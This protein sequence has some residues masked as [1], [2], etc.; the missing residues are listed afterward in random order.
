M[1]LS[2]LH[3]ASATDIMEGIDPS[4]HEKLAYLQMMVA[5]Q[6]K[7]P[8]PLITRVRGMIDPQYAQQAGRKATF[9]SW[10]K[11]A[12]R[13]EAKTGTAYGRKIRVTVLESTV[14]ELINEGFFSDIGG[15]IV[16]KLKEVIGDDPKEHAMVAKALDDNPS[17]GWIHRYARKAQQPLWNDEGFWQKLDQTTNGMGQKIK[18]MVL[19]TYKRA[20]EVSEATNVKDV[21]VLTECVIEEAKISAVM[22]SL[23]LEPDAINSL[24]TDFGIH[25]EDYDI[26]RM[27]EALQNAKGKIGQA[28]TGLQNLPGRAGV[29]IQQKAGEAMGAI[30]QKAGEIGQQV[31]STAD[32]GRVQK[33]NMD[34]ADSVV[35]SSAF[36]LSTA[37]VQSPEQA[38]QAVDQTAQQLGL[39]ADA[40]EIVSSNELDDAPRE[41][42]GQA[43]DETRDPMPGHFV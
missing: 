39:P 5:R 41:M 11:G 8:E 31:K 20:D 2:A 6:G 42:P 34:F 38:K 26:S 1:K 7:D 17:L 9:Q 36:I 22:K 24:M 18:A 3:Q 16:Q 32:V 35:L 25:D 37:N 14:R 33:A 43:G 12:Q 27:K 23:G 29:A 40:E 21:S 4:V 28:V 19:A 13:D 10:I 15:A 30:Q